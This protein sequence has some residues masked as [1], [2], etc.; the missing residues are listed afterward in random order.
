MKRDVTVTDPF[1]SNYFTDT[2]F[3]KL[4]SLM[5]AER[6][7]ELAK[8]IKLNKIDEK[9]FVRAYLL[10]NQN[11]IVSQT[12][13]LILGYA[14]TKG[15]LE[16]YRPVSDAYEYKEVTI[17]DLKEATR[18]FYGDGDDRTLENYLVDQGFRTFNN[19]GRRLIIPE[20][21][22]LMLSAY[23]GSAEID[24]AEAEY[25]THA[26][27]TAIV[28]YANI[29]GEAMG[30]DG[31]K[32]EGPYAFHEFDMGFMEVEGRNEREV[33]HS[34]TLAFHY[35]GVPVP[36]Y[37]RK[38][39]VILKEDTVAGH[40]SKLMKLQHNERLAKQN[41]HKIFGWI[42]SGVV[43]DKALKVTLDVARAQLRE[44]DPESGNC[45]LKQEYYNAVFGY[46]DNAFFDAV[47]LGYRQGIENRS[48]LI[49]ALTDA[50]KRMDKDQRPLI[51]LK[52]K[53]RPEKRAQEHPWLANGKTLLDYLDNE[54]AIRG[55][56]YEP[57]EE[58]A[59][60]FDDADVSTVRLHDGTVVLPDEP[61]VPE[62]ETSG[63]GDAERICESIVKR[64]GLDIKDRLLDKLK[65]SPKIMGLFGALPTDVYKTMTDRGTVLDH[66]L[67]VMFNVYNDGHLD[68]FSFR[69]ENGN[70]VN[71]KEVML[72]AAL[73]HDIGKLKG[74]AD[75]EAGS[76]DFIKSN[77]SGK[78]SKFEIGLVSY[79]I[80]N[81]IVGKLLQDYI[82]P[83]EADAL[84]DKGV[85]ALPGVSKAQLF[86]LAVSFYCADV[87]QRTFGRHIFELNPDNTVKLDHERRP[88][89]PVDKYPQFE[90]LTKLVRSGAAGA[91]KNIVDNDAP[92]TQKEVKDL[93]DKARAVGSNDKTPEGNTLVRYDSTDQFGK[94]FA[95]KNVAGAFH[96]INPEKLSERYVFVEK[97]LPDEKIAIQHEDLEIDWK[98]KLTGEKADL[99]Q[100]KDMTIERASHI[101][102]W[103]EQVVRNEWKRIEDCPFLVAQID[104][105]TFPGGF[106]TLIAEF[107]NGDRDPHHLLAANFLPTVTDLTEA[108]VMST[109]NDFERSV[110]DKA[111]ARKPSV[112]RDTAEFLE[113]LKGEIKNFRDRT[114]CE[115]AVARSVIDG[116]LQSLEVPVWGHH[117][118]NLSVLLFLEQSSSI[119]ELRSDLG[120]IARFLNDM[121]RRYNVVSFEFIKIL[122]NVKSTELF[123][124]IL[125]ASMDFERAFADEFQEMR[126]PDLDIP[127]AMHEVHVVVWSMLKWEI[128]EKTKIQYVRNFLSLNLKTIREMKSELLQKSANPED[129]KD[130]ILILTMNAI[131]GLAGLSKHILGVYFKNED[132]SVL[133]PSLASV[134]KG[135]VL[136][137]R[138]TFFSNQEMFSW[139][140]APSLNSGKGSASA[141]KD[142]LA[143]LDRFYRIFESRF[144]DEVKEYYV[145]RLTRALYDRDP[146]G[147]SVNFENLIDLI[148]LIFTQQAG[149]PR[150]FE[151]IG[152]GLYALADSGKIRPFVEAIKQE[153]AKRAS[154]HY[155]AYVMGLFG[156]NSNELKAV[157]K[158]SDEGAMRAAL[159]RLFDMIDDSLARAEAWMGP[160]AVSNELAGYNGPLF[161]NW[162]KTLS[163]VSIREDL[164]SHMTGT[165][166]E[167]RM[168]YWA[169]LSSA[170]PLF[171]KVLL[172]CPI[173]G[174][175]DN[176]HGNMNTLRRFSSVI[177]ALKKIMGERG[178]SL[179]SYL[180]GAVLNNG[181]RH[182]VKEIETFYSGLTKNGTM[183]SLTDAFLIYLKNFKD[184][185]ERAQGKKAVKRAMSDQL[186]ILGIAGQLLE[187]KAGIEEITE[188]S[189]IGKKI[190]AVV[191]WAL[192]GAGSINAKAL[193]SDLSPDEMAALENEPTRALLRDQ[194]RRIIGELLYSI[195]GSN[196]F[197]TIMLDDV[198]LAKNVIAITSLYFLLT[199]KQA[200]LKDNIKKV[201]SEFVS[202][203]N[204]DG[205]RGLVYSI[206]E[207]QEEKARLE[208]AGCDARLFDRGILVDSILV[209]ANARAV[210][211]M[212]LAKAT[213]LI[214][215]V[216][217]HGVLTK[218]EGAATK[219]VDSKAARKFLHSIQRKL[220]D[221]LVK[222]AEEI[223]K[224]IE[225][226]EKAADEL[227]GRTKEKVSIVISKDPIDEAS[228]GCMDGSGCY[229]INDIHK[230]M[231]PSIAFTANRMFARAYDEAG[232]LIGACEL[233]LTDKGIVV[234]SGAY[235]NRPDLDLETAWV[236]AW[237]SLA[238]WAPNGTVVV[239][240]EMAGWSLLASTGQGMVMTETFKAENRKVLW[241]LYEDF[242]LE[243]R[244]LTERD[245]DDGTFYAIKKG[246]ILTKV[247]D[248]E[249]TPYH[250]VINATTEAPKAS[251]EEAA[252]ASTGWLPDRAVSFNRDR[253][254]KNLIAGEFPKPYL[255]LIKDMKENS[256]DPNTVTPEQ[257]APFFAKRNITVTPD[258]LSKFC[259]LIMAA[260]S[261]TELG[262]R[263]VFSL[264]AAG[265][266]NPMDKSVE[267]ISVSALPVC[268]KPA[269]GERS[270]TAEFEMEL[271]KILKNK[272][273]GQR[274]TKQKT[275]TFYIG[276]GQGFV[277]PNKDGLRHIVDDFKQHLLKME[278]A[279]QDITKQQM[280]L[281]VP[282][283]SS[284]SLGTDKDGYEKFIAEL[285]AGR[286]TNITVIQDA[287][288]DTDF[289]VTEMA[290]VKNLPDP[291]A[292]Y[293]IARKIVAC[294]SAASDLDRDDI[295]RQ[296]V[297][298]LMKI[299]DEKDFRRPK[300]ADS[301]KSWFDDFKMLKLRPIDYKDLADYMEAHLAIAT[302]L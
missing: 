221:L 114:G 9:T 199:E 65:R 78:L 153:T 197:P 135:F 121:S 70:T 56:R 176:W 66:T 198:L 242:K 61:G 247:P 222:R 53:N 109:I 280:V 158:L 96:V 6:Y 74:H 253:M 157:L 265:D 129:E 85:R 105:I 35:K 174:V 93:L 211:Q 84:L 209:P 32:P 104:R 52:R 230:E 116:F 141:L 226:A 273:Y 100:F 229:A 148:E 218:E 131:K 143:L 39:T 18:R 150:N 192:E 86:E 137:K 257:I 296:L 115:D 123:R 207:N 23:R 30:E 139:G 267:V 256:I 238:Q 160:D 203:G 20:T 169:I 103:Y 108:A 299:S 127:P 10:N 83:G 43:Q 133:Y 51:A 187:T 92:L 220:P 152:Q 38:R 88:V 269:E 276:Q 295:W 117:D 122:F 118:L 7:D 246:I 290:K 140:M 80:G 145:S 212:I 272:D 72:I 5:I 136:R 294:R 27:T 147:Y 48:M 283:L 33:D 177:S 289:G 285:V 73:F 1:Y 124:A 172:K 46:L 249:V 79:L 91:R 216:V 258:E 266:E 208:A 268:L 274:D 99:S 293:I 262:D 286:E 25:L 175:K 263:R 106:D 134:V 260:A 206:K 279:G 166:P 282:S 146:K 168:S 90:E 37:A 191:F 102:A 97:G 17:D 62:R 228:I 301:W 60:T 167:M 12:S 185:M 292:R 26:I 171:Q 89:I 8:W 271:G 181:S 41:L 3:V 31:I 22:D 149:I 112:R 302:A 144:G 111:E 239:P 45:G 13:D 67:T 107:K 186:S 75:H 241:R 240:E 98:I 15:I 2:V 278:A 42:A 63:S 213:N 224:E 300:A 125:Q 44:L 259:A 255:F 205:L 195:T 250:D 159:S 251:Q 40:I 28:H 24:H 179:L 64:S 156:N 297:D 130:F 58:T 36:E 128:D 151:Y 142:Q 81:D 232:R 184:V 248:L 178:D 34:V 223:I 235:L 219:I 227:S 237:R 57:G 264:A 204:V 215:I 155:C 252:G 59:S 288:S 183:T 190:T 231:P 87:G 94:F 277:G 19:D 54:K 71:G 50:M 101:L 126:D 201:L 214:E 165:L 21:L 162:M 284:G 29:G 49:K 261:G 275:R 193:V 55:T 210:R 270:G 16:G 217:E 244:D 95:T 110:V 202:S 164:N 298:Y 243:D 119:E 236:A 120:M 138:S 76:L 132:P 189:G 245:E 154:G 68:Q 287:Y 161:G 82:N 170:E 196:E 77:L 69:D 225:Q 194:F 47:S 188:L 281:Y 291:T 113:G 254:V 233:A 234:Y 11:F 14:G 182:L 163:D 173:V 180:S 4:R 200:S